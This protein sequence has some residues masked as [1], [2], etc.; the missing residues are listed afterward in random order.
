MDLHKAPQEDPHLPE[1]RGDRILLVVVCLLVGFFFTTVL[2]SNAL[3][4]PQTESAH[5]FQKTL[6]ELSQS[7]LVLTGLV[8]LWAVFR[9]KWL[10]RFFKGYVKKTQI[11]ILVLFG[12]VLFFVVW[13]SV[14]ELQ[15]VI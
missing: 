6:D 5:I 15:K 10:R 13:L 12:A 3:W 9:P 14:H 4:K 1:N 11:T 8:M 7:F 2:S